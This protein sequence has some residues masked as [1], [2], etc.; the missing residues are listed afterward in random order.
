MNIDDKH[1]VEPL[2]QFRTRHVLIDR[3]AVDRSTLPLFVFVFALRMQQVKGSNANV[4]E[5]RFNITLL[6]VV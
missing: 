1:L 3:I 4:V 2:N 6:R 5:M